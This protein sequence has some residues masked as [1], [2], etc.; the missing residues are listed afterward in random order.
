VPR[1]GTFIRV[2]DGPRAGL[3]ARVA[4]GRAFWIHNCQEVEG[5][6]PGWIALDIVG[7]DAYENAHPTV[8]DSAFVRRPDGLIARAAGTVLIGLGACPPG[9]CT[10][11]VNVDTA[12]FTEYERAHLTM[13]DG[14]YVRRPDGA[15]ARAVGGALLGIG[16]CALLN[17][18]PGWVQL[19]DAGFNNYGGMIR[20]VIRWTIRTSKAPKRSNLCL[21]PG[22]KKPASCSR[23]Q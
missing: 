9:G 18:C 6:C 23:T 10:D 8:A 12:S 13:T 7:Y 17:G 14:T 11:A 4:G 22:A 20:K 21:A 2:P 19:D 5:G 1:N 3:I 16:S 15:I